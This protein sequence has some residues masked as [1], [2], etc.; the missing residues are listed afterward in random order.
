M[1]SGGGRL[2]RRAGSSRGHPTEN[3]R[4]GPGDAAG[5][6]GGGWAIPWG[7]RV[8]AANPSI[9]RPRKPLN[10]KPPRGRGG[11][12]GEVCYRSGS[13]GVAGKDTEEGLD[14]GVGAEVPV[15]IE[16]G[17]IA[18]GAAEAREAAE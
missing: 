15:A 18:G 17:G 10:A 7:A 11:F 9:T 6:A 1:P 16:V 3:V 12:C 4:A 8:G 2:F 13:A 5:G 14:V